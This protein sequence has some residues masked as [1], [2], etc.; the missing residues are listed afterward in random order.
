VTGTAQQPVVLES[1]LAPAVG[2]GHDVVGFPARSPLAPRLAGRSLAGR[3]LR[4]RPLAMRLDDVEPA[5]LAD[6]FV[7]FLDLL[8]DVPRA[9]ADLPLVYALVTAEGPARRLHG[10]PA[11]SA[12]RLAGLVPLGL[13][14]LIGRDDALAAS[15]HERHIGC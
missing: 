7:A 6:A 4:S 14:P 9:A 12:D 3:R 2:N 1:A 13:P 10:S 15:A 8:P 5:E 11:P